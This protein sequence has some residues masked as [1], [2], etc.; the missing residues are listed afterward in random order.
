MPQILA[1][2]VISTLSY[3]FDQELVSATQEVLSNIIRHSC[4][5][6]P[7][8]E[9][10]MHVSFADDSCTIEFLDYG[11]IF[12]PASIAAIDLDQLH[13]GG[14]GLY[15]ARSSVND[16]QYSPGGRGQPNRW[17][18]SK[19][20]DNLFNRPPSKS[21]D[22]GTESFTIDIDPSQAISDAISVKE[23]EEHSPALY[24]LADEIKAGEVAPH[25]RKKAGSGLNRPSCSR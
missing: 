6:N 21:A 3:S 2:A 23:A 12:D 4:G 20:L 11:Q 13:E 7:S 9:I 15:I 1:D 19:T 24:K 18:L 10:E 16:L 25:Y 8:S 5:S 22:D 14:M 17:R